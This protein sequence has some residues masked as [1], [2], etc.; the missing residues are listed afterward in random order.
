MFLH[1]VSDAVGVGTARPVI[2]LAAGTLL[3]HMDQLDAAKAFT[4]PMDFGVTIRMVRMEQ[5]GSGAPLDSSPKPGRVG[6]RKSEGL[7]TVDIHYNEISMVLDRV[8]DEQPGGRTIPTSQDYL[9]TFV[10][11][12]ETALEVLLNWC[13]RKDAWADK[14]YYLDHWN[15]AKTA[16][17]EG[18]FVRPYEF[19]LAPLM[20]DALDS[21][22]ALCS[23][24]SLKR[25]SFEEL[26][27]AYLLLRGVGWGDADYA[28]DVS[29]DP[30]RF[31]QPALVAN[32]ND[33]IAS[34]P[35][36]DN[37]TGYSIV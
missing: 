20:R 5:A 14:D 2:L 22:W 34:A 25:E 1:I 28:A 35:P 30:N 7:L 37:S 12:M 16:I 8:A 24:A 32:F 21:S 26:A 36:P 3:H 4:V 6:H 10:E 29:A 31:G 27:Q 19:C 11:R 17:K 23:Q 13:D 15:D 33:N 9:D 18:A